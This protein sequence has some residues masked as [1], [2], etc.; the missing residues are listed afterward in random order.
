MDGLKMSILKNI[1][2]IFKGAKN[3]KIQRG[4]RWVVSNLYQSQNYINSPLYEN[5]DGYDNEFLRNIT[6]PLMASR[7]DMPQYERYKIVAQSRYYEKRAPI[8]NRLA[9]LFEEF[10][11]GPT[12]M[13][14][15]PESSNRIWNNK[16]REYFENW[17]EN[18]DDQGFK[19]LKTIQGII[20]RTWF[21]DG[22]I[23][24]LLKN[25]NGQRTI[26]LVETQ[27]VQGGD[28]KENTIDGIRYDSNMKPIGYYIKNL[29][30]GNYS[31]YESEDV[32]HLFT[33]IRPNQLRG[34]PYC[35]PVLKQLDAYT[36]LLSFEMKHS[37]NMSRRVGVITRQAE[38]QAIDTIEYLRAQSMGE[39][40]AA[41]NPDLPKKDI[42]QEV[43]KVSETYGGEIAYLNPGENFKELITG[44][45]TQETMNLFLFLTNEICEGVG[46]AKVFYHPESTQGT[47]TRAIIEV[48][49]S[50]F[51]GH[52]SLFTELMRNIYLFSIKGFPAGG[53][54]NWSR[55]NVKPPRSI[56]VDI[57]RDSQKE[58][59]E[60][61]SGIKTFRDAYAERGMDW[62]IEL[63]QC[64]EE[65][66][67]INEIAKRYGITTE[68]LLSKCI[69]NPKPDSSLEIKE[70]QKEKEKL[71]TKEKE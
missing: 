59:E 58:I 47:V 3:K 57:G 6:K 31:Y 2:S 36:R 50:F 70:K 40:I 56:V 5:T 53:V 30:N 67:T 65:A 23:F 43:Q 14:M 32:I 49:K 54:K 27:E 48:Q 37:L 26:R 24:I 64:A 68:Q 38:E 39:E 52:S 19:H 29:H 71:L 12:G 18:C 44:R 25:N 28:S 33:P 15:I 7:H 41:E 60:L 8:Y 13:Q 69:I 1:A 11:V 66:A 4:S 34:L 9:D 63:E 51:S 17:S 35:Y 22:E 61:K 62:R 45:P 46:I 55:V 20:A 42:E 10:I 21:V 16:A